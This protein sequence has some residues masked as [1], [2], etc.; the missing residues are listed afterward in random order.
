MDIRDLELAHQI[1]FHCGDLGRRAEKT[2]GGGDEA[3]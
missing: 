1:R 2:R 3:W